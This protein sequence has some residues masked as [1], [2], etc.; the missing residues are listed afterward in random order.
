MNII[1]VSFCCTET[2]LSE[3]VPPL[4]AIWHRD[5]AQLIGYSPG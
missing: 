5:L 3:K 1:V 4:P 2:M